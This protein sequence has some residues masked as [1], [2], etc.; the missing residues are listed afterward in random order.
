ML[1][2]CI[3]LTGFDYGFG[4]LMLTAGGLVAGLWLFVV[5]SVVWV[6][7]FGFGG[8]F[9]FW[10]FACSFVF[11]SAVVWFNSVVAVAFY[12]CVRVLL[13]IFAIVDL[14][15]CA[16]WCHILCLWLDLVVTFFGYCI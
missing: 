11:S 6:L 16:I 5:Y 2:Q 14:L 10:V 9:F 13:L 7:L 15:V 4:C 8:L 3:G 12:W 1:L